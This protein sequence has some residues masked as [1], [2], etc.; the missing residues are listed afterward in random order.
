VIV[1]EVN[2]QVQRTIAA[3]YLPWLASHVA[4]M[5][6]LPG[7]VS[8]ESFA[9]PDQHDDTRI[10]CCVQYRLRDRVALEAYL[11]DHAAGMRAD[12]VAR[13]GDRFSAQRRVL[14]P[15]PA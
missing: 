9:V 6:A 5:L 4:Q 12:A 15:L 13:F 11:R 1:Y 8:A 10:A 2:L 3:E 7:F 14:E